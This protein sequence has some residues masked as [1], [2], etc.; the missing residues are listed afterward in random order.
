MTITTHFQ[1][2]FMT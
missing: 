2:L 1:Q